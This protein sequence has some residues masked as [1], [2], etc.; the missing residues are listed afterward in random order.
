V[1]RALIESAVAAGFGAVVLT[2]DAPRGGR[3]ERDL[4]TGFA[5]PG[6]VDAPALRAAVGA[7]DAFTIAE[8]FGLLDPSL[9]WATLAQLAAELP[10]PV[11]VKGI[12]T[13]EDALLAAEHGA[14]AVIVSNH[15][16]RQLDNVAAALDVL[17]E[18]VDAVGDRLEVLVDG[19]VRRGTDVLVALALGARAVL[20]GRAPL[21]GLAAG[22]EA[23]ARHVLE[24][25][26]AEIELAMTLLGTP[27]PAAVTRAHVR[28]STT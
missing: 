18:V 15:G 16:G 11:I 13:A 8:F 1:T 22:G 27:T 4:R 26:H 2:V 23:G 14:A 12:Q 7:P 10:V 25:L 9:T 28:G 24:L 5:I 6:H 3:R 17:P 21:W 19:G 20:C